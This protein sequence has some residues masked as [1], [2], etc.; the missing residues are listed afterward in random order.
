MSGQPEPN[1]HAEPV[2]PTIGFMT[3]TRVDRTDGKTADYAAP[4]RN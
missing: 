1:I 3:R 2:A 4:N